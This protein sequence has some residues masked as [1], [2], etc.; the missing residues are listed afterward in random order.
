MV[1]NFL[2]FNSGKRTILIITDTMQPGGVDS[3]VL[4]LMTS[5][6]NSGWK[7]E[8]LIDKETNSSLKSLNNRLYTNNQ[9]RCSSCSL[10]SSMGMFKNK[11]SNNTK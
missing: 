2:N 4:G 7:V 8:L 9:S 11:G 6:Q 10:W 3:Y 5:A 1:S